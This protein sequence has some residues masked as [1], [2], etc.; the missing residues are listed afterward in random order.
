MKLLKL[1][2][3]WYWL[4]ELNLVSVLS[5]FIG[6]FE[7]ESPGGLLDRNAAGYKSEDEEDDMEL[8]APDTVEDSK[9]QPGDGTF[10]R[11]SG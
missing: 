5:Y 6:N 9:V 2:W 3:Q 7:D 11:P 1:V 10:S 8:V 4:V